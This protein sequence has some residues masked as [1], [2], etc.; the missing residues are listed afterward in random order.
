MVLKLISYMYVIKITVNKISSKFSKIHLFG[1]LVR[2][3]IQV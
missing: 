3:S 1:S 2:E